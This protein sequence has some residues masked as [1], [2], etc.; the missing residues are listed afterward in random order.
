MIDHDQIRKT[1]S[2]FYTRAVKTGSG[3]CGPGSSGC[4]GSGATDV[5]PKGF[6]A[7]FAGYGEDT[8]G[9]PADAVHNSFGCGNP[10]AFCDV[11]PGEVVLDL[12]SGA[13]IDLL[14]AARKVGP[15]GHVIGV[16]MTDE[17]IERAR[18]NA[19]AAGFTNIEVRQGIIEALPI[20]AES[21]DWV[22]SNCVINLSP[23]KNRV[24]REI[25]RVLKPGGRIR[26]SDIV[27]QDIP[28]WVRQSMSLYASCVSG[29]VSEQEYADGL[30]QAGLVDVEVTERFPYDQDQIRAMIESEI[31]DDVR[32]GA[33]GARLAAEVAGK[34]C[35]AKFQATKP[36]HTPNT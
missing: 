10:L 25:A 11:K 13:G 4:C 15:T 3:C 12:G 26:V 1:V 9:L 8:T 35:S 18:A 27:V 32:M 29:A 2:D 31:P 33:D 6:A 28:D 36:H 22:I 30:R 16:D 7:Q 14:V 34:V 5:L 17:M 20:E 24:F 23:E 21:V 19:A